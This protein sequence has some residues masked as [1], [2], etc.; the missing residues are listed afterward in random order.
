MSHTETQFEEEALY[1]ARPN[2]RNSKKGLVELVKQWGIAKDDTAAEKILLVVIGVCILI[3]ILV[4]SM[5]LWPHKPP[6]PRII[7]SV[8]VPS[9]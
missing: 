7:P 8:T 1:A 3:M 9:R 5:F 2:A 6:L 4:M